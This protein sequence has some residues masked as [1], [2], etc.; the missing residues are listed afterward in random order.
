MAPHGFRRVLVRGD[1]LG[2]L[3]GRAT[4]G[5]ARAEERTVKR[6]QRIW[7]RIQA[8]RGARALPAAPWL[9]V[10]YRHRPDAGP[11]RAA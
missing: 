8:Q 6:L 4:R 1:V 7:I 10:Y 11:D 5:F 9:D 3:A 2:P